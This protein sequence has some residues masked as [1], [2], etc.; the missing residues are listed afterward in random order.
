MRSNHP[1]IILAALMTIPLSMTQLRAQEPAAAASAAPTAA[2]QPPQPAE[3]TQDPLISPD[4]AKPLLQPWY[5]LKAKA[6]DKQELEINPSYTFLY[7][8]ATNVIDDQNDVLGGR[9]DLNINWTLLHVGQKDTGSIGFLFRS[10]VNIG[11][12]Q[13]FNLSQEVGDDMVMNALQGGGKQHPATVNLIYWRQSFFDDKLAFYVGKI[14]PNQHIDLDPVNNDETRQFLAAPFDG[15]LSNP[16]EGNYAPGVAMEWTIVDDFYFHALAMDALGSPGTGFG[17]T[18]DGKYY[19]A[20]QFSWEPTLKDLGKGN[21][22]VFGWHTQTDSGDEGSGIGVGFSQEIGKDGWAPFGRWGYGDD[23]VTSMRQMVS[24]GIG[25]LHPFGRRGDMFGIGLAWGDP[26]DSS[27]RQ[28]T[29]LET[30]YRLKLTD[31]LELSPDVELFMPPSSRE[32]Q[33]FVAVF[34]IRLKA[35]F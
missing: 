11:E 24:G 8:N 32:N 17:T 28:Q 19:E 16:Q 22:R 35:L 34:G 1:C 5:D 3:D 30:F 29:M 33:D 14:H 21:Y 23:Q 9:L 31:S 27:L 13:N 18:F 15:N 7:Q 20:A 12:N 26:S 4:P 6:K 10:G 25:N 2:Q